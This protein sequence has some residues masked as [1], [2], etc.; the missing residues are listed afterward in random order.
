M[1]P[2]LIAFR[3]LD[4]LVRKLSEQ[5]ASYRRRALSSEQRVR[6]LEQEINAAT[7]ALH[8]LRGQ[9]ETLRTARDQSR[10]EAARL[11]TE[12]SAAT[13]ELSRVQAAF[14]EIAAR[15]TPEGR[16]R[17]LASQNAQLR[18][19]LSDARDRTA[20]LGERVRFLRQQ[21]GQGVER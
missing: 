1:R 3:E 14:E 12:L 7:D 11:A 21:I 9:A 13:T 15:S 20:Q 19:T 2:D 4:T 18:A 17:E 16:D 10:D 6:D 5:L 8:A